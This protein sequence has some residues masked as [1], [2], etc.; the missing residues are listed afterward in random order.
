MASSEHDQ[1]EEL[2]YVGPLRHFRL[3]QLC[4][5]EAI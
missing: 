4:P 5:D 2:L 3:L 1:S